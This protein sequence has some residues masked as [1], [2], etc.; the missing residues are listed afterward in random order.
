MNFQAGT[1]KRAPVWIRGLGFE[2]LWRIKE[3]P[4]L[5]RRYW[6]DGQALFALLLFRVVP[7]RVE[8]FA[9]TCKLRKADAPLSI[10]LRYDADIV[11]ISLAGSATRNYIG[12]AIQCFQ[13]ET[14]HVS[15]VEL[16]LA[17]VSNIDSRFLGLLIMLR[18]TL[19]A[20]AGELKITGAT[21]ALRR[22]FR[23]NNAEYL[24]DKTRN[25]HGQSS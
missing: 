10:A 23:L 18:K 5:W 14:S 19:L 22:T 20:N 4:S 16:N 12:K 6:V 13:D 21:R 15:Y 8:I 2:W 7:Q 25:E 1:V 24:L 3:E 17:G 11:Q 9:R